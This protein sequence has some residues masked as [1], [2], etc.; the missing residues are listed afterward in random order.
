[1][2]AL[3]SGCV[4]PSLHETVWGLAPLNLKVPWLACVHA[5]PQAQWYCPPI[6]LEVLAVTT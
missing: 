5:I 4:R 3:V 6:G 2:H 1:M